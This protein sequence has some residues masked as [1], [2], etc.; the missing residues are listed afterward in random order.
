M[1]FDQYNY[2]LRFNIKSHEVIFNSTI[3]LFRFRSFDFIIIVMIFVDLFE[4][5][6]SIL[7]LPIHQYVF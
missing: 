2:F 3:F 6:N 4:F 5:S 1:I 7:F